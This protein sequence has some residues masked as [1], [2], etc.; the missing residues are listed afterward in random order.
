MTTCGVACCGLSVPSAVSLWVLVCCG[1]VSFPSAIVV[2]QVLQVA[3]TRPSVL[4]LVAVLA[5]RQVAPVAMTA[6]RMVA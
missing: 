4:P 1:P 3:L 2:R 5:E 6:S